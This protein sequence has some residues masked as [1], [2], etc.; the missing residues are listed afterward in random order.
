MACEREEASKRER[1]EKKSS[2][3]PD[4][5]EHV[6]STR[7]VCWPGVVQAFQTKDAQHDVIHGVQVADPRDGVWHVER[8]NEQAVESLH[9]QFN[10]AADVHGEVG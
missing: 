10:E 4:V 8:G 1:R 9:D 6:V 5:G 2:G 3:D 7:T